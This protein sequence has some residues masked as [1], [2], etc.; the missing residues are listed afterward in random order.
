[1]SR[2]VFLSFL[3]TGNYKECVYKSKV[4]GESRVVKFVQESIIDLYC[5]DF[6]QQDKA[7]I[8]LTED[9]EKTHWESLKPIL[10]TKNITFE[11]IKGVSEG[12]SESE[13]WAIFE[14]VFNVLEKEDEII[15]DVTHGF[16]SLPMLQIVLLNY[17][18]SLKQI[19]VNNILYGAFEALGPSYNIEERIPNPKDRKAP[20]LDLTA[21]STIQEWTFGAESFIQTGQ[22][23]TITSLA[24]ENIR[25]ILIESMG[26]DETA[27][28]INKIMS[29]LKNIELTL[30][31][32]RGKLILEDNQVEKVQIE[33]E[34]LIENDST[35][36]APLKPILRQ[37]KN[38]FLPF[39]QKAH[40]EAAVEW[41][42]EHG[43]V[44]QG[45][46]QL[47]E[48]II[49][50]ICIINNLDSGNLEYREIV[51]QAL[52]ILD[53]DHDEEKW[54]APANEN[55]ELVKTIIQSEFVKA[56]LSN[57]MSLSEYRNDINHGG[58]LK[59]ALKNGDKFKTKLEEHYLKF[60]SLKK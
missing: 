33:L 40:W 15:L 28:S 21:F 18:K 34:N 29:S 14:K 49:S 43:L 32:N 2:K 55:K 5:S 41:C 17:A 48:G 45:I 22:T 38:K 8:F 27:S 56:Y 59:K 16:R 42:I 4:K 3:G 44:Q 36:F 51:S 23:K 11:G 25:P 26:G 31:T 57:Y 47:Q 58:Y 39:E 6:S 60:Q 46:T 10:E 53:K 54:Y 20:L 7:Y 52:N 1:M 30:S 35:V 37:I 13:I 9:A 24:K 50:H 12:Y 19:K